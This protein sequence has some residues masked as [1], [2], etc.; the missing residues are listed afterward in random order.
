MKSVL[1][2]LG[3]VAVVA[4]QTP[5]PHQVLPAQLEDDARFQLMAAYGSYCSKESLMKWDCMWCK[6]KMGDATVYGVVENSTKTEGQAFVA[7]MNSSNQ[8]IVA[9]RGSANIP[10]WIEDFTFVKTPLT[11]PGVPKGVEVHEGFLAS[12][13]DLRDDIFV[14]VA[15]AQKD[16]PTCSLHVTGHSL[17]AAEACLSAVDFRLRGM[18]PYLWTFGEPRVG[19]KAFAEFFYEKTTHPVFRMVNKKD[20]VPHLPLYDQFFHHRQRE[21]WRVENG[22]YIMCDNTGEDPTCSRSIKLENTSI[23]NHVEYMGFIQVCI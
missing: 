8:I 11:W 20:I 13:E 22:T 4:S 23:P 6:R 21:V 12:Y 3:V 16:C 19:N 14:W 5:M 2:M 18:N 7:R 10:N 1:S 17:G 9:F 15:Q